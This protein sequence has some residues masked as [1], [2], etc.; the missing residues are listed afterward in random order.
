MFRN[1]SPSPT[2]A[3]LSDDKVVRSAITPPIAVFLVGLALS[4]ALFAVFVRN[5]LHD[6]LQQTY[7]EEAAP[8]TVA[9]VRSIDSSLNAISS[10][11]GLYAASNEV[12]RDEFRA[13]V[14]QNFVLYDKT[15][16]V[17]W[18]PRVSAADR[19]AYEALARRDGLKEFRITELNSAGR[20]VPA[21]ERKEYYPVYFVEPLGGNEA[22]LGF[23]LASNPVR[24]E[25]L[26][27]A[28]DTGRMVST[29]RIQLVQEI[30]EQFGFLAFAPV[31]STG[32]VPNTI[33]ARRE[34][35]MGF[36]L[37]V[38]RIGDILQTAISQTPALAKLNL[39]VLDAA[40]PEGK[41]LLYYRGVPGQDSRKLTANELLL[42]G[43]KTTVLSVADRNWLLVFVP[44][45][46]FAFPESAVPWIVGAFGVLSTLFFVVFLRTA[47]NRTRNIK[48]TVIEQTKELR[49]SEEFVRLITDSLPAVIAYF[50]AKMNVRFI[51]QTGVDWYNCPRENLVGKRIYEN[52]PTLDR[53][54]YLSRVG[55]ILSGE[56][57]TYN[58]PQT[59]PDGTTRQVTISYIPR[60][61]GG[62]DTIGFFCI[63]QDNSQRL[64]IE[65]QLNQ[66]QKMDAIGH[67][68][69]G[70]AHDFNN[71]LMV[72]DG[73]TRRALKDV[74]NPD[75]V[76]AAL[77]E[78]LTGTDRAAQL[79]KQLLSFS[80]RQIMEKRVFRIEEAISEIEALLRQ[81]TGERYEI[82]IESHTDG[83]CVETDASEF[84]QALINLVINARDAMAQGGQV[85][86]ST[87]V[88][89]LDEKFAERH[90]N[91]TPGRFVE[92]AVHDYGTGIDADTLEH[93]FEPFFTTKDQG[94]GTGLGLAMVYGFA[95]HSGGTLDVAS[96]VGEGSIFK[97]Y[98]PAVDRDP[99]IIV[100]EV[101]QV[102]HGQ[103]ETI[104]LVEDDPSLLE[105][106]RGMLDTLGY[107]VI[108]AGDGFEAM[109]VEAEH[110]RDIDLLLSDVVMPNMGGFEA[111][112]IIREVRP[113]IKIVFMS[114]YPN[115]AGFSNEN[116]PDNC[117]FLQKPA[118]PAHLA[119]TIRQELDK[120]VVSVLDDHGKVESYDYA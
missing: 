68:T 56:T 113:E 19:A 12:E 111:A 72:T 80:R 41:S 1:S 24:R 55:R 20:V 91:L 107:N 64:E 117:E 105:L 108:T 8:L 57:E 82:R 43:Y 29:Q 70:I 85:E 100:A 87:R 37:G 93:I 71:I 38:F 62:G 84:N 6:E 33:Q 40:A 103:G 26:G 116:V 34:T 52:T 120:P 101:E 75:A 88:V 22:A 44:R 77:E 102:H 4:A 61:D 60:I 81:S 90:Q 15:Q 49:E 46:D 32:S 45:T 39:Y 114:G 63:V 25:A 10:I 66:A 110:D 95:Q 50:D 21:A 18:I 92:V 54:D 94:K 35:L 96:V 69:G 17:E 104:L 73:Y 51:N 118:K 58:T 78:V 3:R 115:R 42:G 47:Q 5:T 59:Y 65:R 74:D 48:K 79:T 67:L 97:I 86:I 2:N 27:R 36:A 23:D 11:S 109:E 16:A 119:Q 99:H 106:V 98:L 112:V 89:D 9:I 13:Y 31:Y 7:Q 30:G 83:A 14:E 76:T 28:R 53:E